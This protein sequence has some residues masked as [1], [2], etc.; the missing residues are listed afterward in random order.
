MATIDYPLGRRNQIFILI[1][2][3]QDF[4]APVVSSVQ[5][6]ARVDGIIITSLLVLIHRLR[7]HIPLI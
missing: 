7:V 6:A 2:Q 1:T 5:L 4:D 3:L